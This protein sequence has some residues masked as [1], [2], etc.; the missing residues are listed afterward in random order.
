[1]RSS[2]FIVAIRVPSKLPKMLPIILK[3]NTIQRRFHWLRE[4][5]E[6]NEFVLVKIHTDEK[7][8]DMLTKVLSMEKLVVCRRR[9]GLVDSPPTGVKGEF[10]V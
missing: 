10:V 1:M 5:V 3:P 9:T 2:H 7:G 6:E 8:S 4:R